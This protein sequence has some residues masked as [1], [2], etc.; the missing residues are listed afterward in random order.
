MERDL[1]AEEGLFLPPGTLDDVAQAR[2]AAASH[3][4]NPFNKLDDSGRS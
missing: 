2:V 4:P 1:M 3:L